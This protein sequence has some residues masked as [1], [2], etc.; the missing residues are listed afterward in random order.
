MAH[1][2]Y[3]RTSSVDQ[4]NSLHSQVERFKALGVDPDLIYSEQRSGANTDRPKLRECLRTVRKGD[5]VVVT[6]LDRLARSMTDLMEI[7]ATLEKKGVGFTALDQPEID[8]TKPTGR[9]LLG[10]LASVAEFER[11]LIK[12]RQ[13]EGIGPI[14]E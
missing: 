11:A 5:V 7:L 6:R 9:L 8:T 13:A 4:T 10:V 3:A 1:I 12:E 14:L 2:G